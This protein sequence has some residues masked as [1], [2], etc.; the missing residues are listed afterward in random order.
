MLL[1]LALSNILLQNYVIKEK[2]FHLIGDSTLEVVMNV[3]Y[4]KE[5]LNNFEI[6]KRFEILISSTWTVSFAFCKENIRGWH[7]KSESFLEVNN[8]NGEHA[9]RE[10]C[11]VKQALT[12]KI[13]FVTYKCNHSETARVKIP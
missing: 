12:I 1:D 13:K 4:I 10:K 6:Y 5:R 3:L 11:T 8:L 2:K 9:I 7:E